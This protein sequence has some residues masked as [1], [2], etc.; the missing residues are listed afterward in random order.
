MNQVNH[1]KSLARLLNEF[2][3]TMCS[4]DR[5]AILEIVTS[6]YCLTCGYY[7]NSENWCYCKRDE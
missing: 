1:A 4:T 2:M 7:D 5:V 6:G 3:D